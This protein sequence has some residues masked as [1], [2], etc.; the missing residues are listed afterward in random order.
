MRKRV[1]SFLVAI[2]SVAV[3]CT[4]DLPPGNERGRLRTAIHESRRREPDLDRLKRVTSI[5]CSPARRNDA[6]TRGT[7]PLCAPWDSIP[8]VEHT[9]FETATDVASIAPEEAVIS[10]SIGRNSRAYPIRYLSRREV[11][12]DVVAGHPVAITYCPLC[13]S[14][15]AFSRR[16][17]DDTLTFRVSGQ[18]RRANLVMFDTQTLSTWQQLTGEALSGSMKGRRLELLPARMVPFEEWRAAHPKGLVMEAPRDYAFEYALDPYWLPGSS[19]EPG[20]DALGRAPRYAAEGVD[21][22]LPAGQRVI[23]VTTRAGAVA[24]PIPVR[25]GRRLILSTRLGRNR[26]VAFLAYGLAQPG[27]ARRFRRGRPGWS[28]IVYEAS[29][30]GRALDFRAR[31]GT[32]LE[33]TTGSEF[34]FFGRGTSGPLQG[35]RLTAPNQLTAFWFAWSGFHPRTGIASR[36]AR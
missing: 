29:L 2:A 4:S 35:A 25:E 22:R 10:I 7:G 23:G 17:G 30:D 1:V 24:F 34:D 9:S 3:G 26:L 21:P 14:A 36:S 27:S 12:N 6:L 28:A 19:K 11:V 18:L 13:N 20:D 5:A 31:A 8:A 32:F 15:V 33:T 16:V